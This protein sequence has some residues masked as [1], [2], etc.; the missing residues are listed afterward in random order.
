MQLI[1]LKHLPKEISMAIRDVKEYYFKM[2]SQYM[3]M[4]A[5]LADFE[6]ALKDGFITEEQMQAAFAEVERVQQNYERLSYIMYLLNLPNRK[7]KQKK[8]NTMNSVLVTEF[9]KL[10]AD[11]KAVELE[12]MDALKLFRAEME[13][14]HAQSETENK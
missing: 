1:T 6:Q 7:S 9:E 8:Y 2:L 13:R 12:N 4:K 14:L 3:E 11:C 5:D 10:G